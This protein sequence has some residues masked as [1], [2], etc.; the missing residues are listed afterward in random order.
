MYTHITVSSVIWSLV[1]SIPNVEVSK[2]I[3][4]LSI[5]GQNM[6]TDLNLFC[7]LVLTKSIIHIT[8]RRFDYFQPF[9]WAQ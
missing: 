4:T 1:T 6:P 2:K 3:K 7:P 9:L 8:D 5:F